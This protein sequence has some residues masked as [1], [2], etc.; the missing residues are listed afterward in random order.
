MEISLSFVGTHLFMKSNIICIKNINFSARKEDLEEVLSVLGG[1]EKLDWK[2]HPVTGEPKG[3]AVVYFVNEEQSQL[4]MDSLDGFSFFERNLKVS[5]FES[6]NS[7][8]IQ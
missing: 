4:A 5:F 1:F 8:Q 2:V 7:G 3:V 6:G